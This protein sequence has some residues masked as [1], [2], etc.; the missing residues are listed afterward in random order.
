VVRR[1]PVLLARLG[2]ELIAGLVVLSWLHHHLA[3]VDV[4]RGLLGLA[5][6]VLFA[7][8]MWGIVTWSVER[9]VVTDSRI[10]LVT[11]LVNRQVAM[12]PLRKVT[13]MSY[14]RSS[15]GWLL[16]YG[17]FVMESAGETQALR[18]IRFLPRPDALYLQLSELLFATGGALAVEEY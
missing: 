4:L 2:L 3:A 1:H 9:F 17:E 16:G 12:L 15:L 11:G 7:R 5:I 6:V 14:R 18:R 13:D 10:L 8:T